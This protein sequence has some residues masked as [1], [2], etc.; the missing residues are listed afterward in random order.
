MKKLAM[1]II[2]ATLV[3]V[4]FAAMADTGGSA[5]AT[6]TFDAVIN[7]VITD[8]WENLTITQND[9]EDSI[10][11]MVGG[12]TVPIDWGTG[13]EITATVQAMTDW[14]VWA[15]YVVNDLGLFNAAGDE[16]AF[17]YLKPDGG[18]AVAL[19]HDDLGFDPLTYTGPYSSM[20]LQDVS[21]GTGV[22][23]L[24]SGES[25]DFDVLWDPSKI[26][27]SASDVLNLTV[28]FVVEDTS[29]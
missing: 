2:L 24:P 20:T 13:F 19:P 23:N 4:P 11:S 14:K 10:A 9:L 5:S 1:G 18:T 22:N 25:E 29:I 12:G 26:D 6:L 16:D 17:L 27:A 7:T 3:L 21:F 8:N 28:K 15:A